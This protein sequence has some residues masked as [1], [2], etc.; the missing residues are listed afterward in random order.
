MTVQTPGLTENEK[1][2]AWRLHVLVEAGYPVTLAEN[3]A[4]SQVDLHRAVSLLTGGC[5][6]EVAADILL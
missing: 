4:A 3:L 1:V 2:E 5:R 6:P